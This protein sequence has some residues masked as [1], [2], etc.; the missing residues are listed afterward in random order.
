MIQAHYLS[1]EEFAYIAIIL[2]VIGLFKLIEDFGISQAIIQRDVISV[3]ES[4]SLFIFN[5]FLCCLLALILF[6]ISPLLAVFFSMPDL[7]GYLPV[8]SIIV[9]LTGPSLL[10]RAFLEKMMY[11]KQLSLIEILRNFLVFISTTFF[12]FLGFGVWGV[13][14]GQIIGISVATCAI[15]FVAIRA[16]VTKLS[17]HFKSSDLIPFLRFGL[18]VSSK[19]LMTFVSHR[20]DELV[21]GYFLTPEIL[22]IY[23]F[24]KNMLEKIRELMSSSFG[25]VLF[26]IFSKFK[27]VPYKLSRAYQMI[28]RYI[29]FSAFPVFFGIAAT[30]HL[31]VPVLFGDQ[32]T[33]S[34]IVFQ[35][36][37][38]AVILLVLTANVSS[39]LLYSVNKPDLVFYIDFVTNLIYFVSLFLS[40]QHGML[41]ILIAYSCYI[42]YKT[43][44]LQYFA[45]LQLV[46]NFWDYFSELTRPALLA[47][48][49]VI[50][51]LLFQLVFSEILDP[52]S[53]LFGSIL[54]GVLVFGLLA[55][56]FAYKIVLELKSAIFEGEIAP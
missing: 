17:L 49:M 12:L 29:A 35:V 2:I 44:S 42:L 6:G 30:A 3:Q 15:L 45:N 8:V 52:T 43:I 34:I 13:I 4:S 37:S 9:L 41:A 27:N 39:S 36:F 24:G 21:I 1:P 18:F 5:I 46:N 40:I 47:I 56:I 54:I 28:S 50:L 51:V 19:Q 11:F 22:G 53:L 26:P 14:Y 55:R 33:N 32:W 10:V 48:A 25:K 23:H 20:L 31:F 7:K 38:V 16:K